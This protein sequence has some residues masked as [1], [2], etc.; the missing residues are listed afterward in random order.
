MPAA[1]PLIFVGCLVGHIVAADLLP[2]WWVPNLTVIGLVLVVSSSPRRWLLPAALAG[3]WMAVWDVRH[4]VLP[5]A[6]YLV[7]G[8]LLQW[9]A[10]S[11]NLADRRLQGFMVA[12]VALLV[13]C[14]SVWAERLASVAVVGLMAVHVAMT[15]AAFLLVR[16]LVGRWMRTEQTQVEG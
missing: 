6:S 16:Q 8:W 1:L 13:I 3:L 5:V 14:G 12:A 4:P 15:Y 7:V 10:R 2:P 11:W 9:L